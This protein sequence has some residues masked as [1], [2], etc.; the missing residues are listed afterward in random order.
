MDIK[1]VLWHSTGANNPNLKRYVQPSDVKPKEDTFTKSEWLNILGINSSGTDW[2]HKVREAGLNC[3]IGKLA[4]GTV[5]TIQTMPWDFAPWGCG[6]YCN[7]GWIQFEICEGDLDDKDYFNKI[8][9]E[10]CEITAYLCKLYNID[11][12]GTVSFRGKTVPTILCHADSHALGLGSNHADVTHWFPKYNKSMETARADVAALLKADGVTITSTAAKKYYRIRKAKDDSKSQIGAYTDLQKAI[13]A[14][15][16][17]GEGYHVFDWEY[18]LVYSYTAPATLSSIY[19]ANSPTKTTYFIGEPYDDTGLEVYAVYSDNSTKVITDY[20]VSGFD[21]TKVGAIT[22]QIT[23]EGKTATF[24]ITVNEKEDVVE[25]EPLD[26]IVPNNEDKTDSLAKLIFN[27]IKK[28]IHM[29]TELF[30]KGE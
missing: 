4:D 24:T 23:F 19:I 20:A 11:P 7:D 10:A 27:I 22:V 3:W 28:L 5:T 12:L 21:S 14:C 25:P 13:N 15:Q 6:G 30:K 2:N 16:K 17:A 8:Y 26:T 1:G 9:K 18:K 29:F